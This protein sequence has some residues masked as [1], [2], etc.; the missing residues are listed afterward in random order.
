MENANEAAMERQ[1][2]QKIAL[3]DQLKKT[4]IVQLSCEKTSISRATYYRWRK[5][6]PHFATACDAAIDEGDEL[7][8][9]MAESKL[10][11]AIKE[12]NFNA[13]SFWLRKRSPRFRDRLE[14]TAARPQEELTEEQ[15]AT[16][17]EALRL[18][19]MTIGQS[20][21]KAAANPSI[22]QPENLINKSSEQTYE[23]PK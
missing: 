4:P 18:A 21:D 16:V 1:K 10:I 22:T 11:T 3:I 19:S 9:D 23:Q 12:Q 7:V 13:I 14:V 15:E 5:E 8:S 6:D 20:K 2:E 17:K